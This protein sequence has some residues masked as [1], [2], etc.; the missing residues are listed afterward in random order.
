MSES[1]PRLKFFDAVSRTAII[2]FCLLNLTQPEMLQ[3]CIKFYPDQ[4]KS[5][6]D[7]D[8]NSFSFAL[9][10]SPPPPPPPPPNHSPSSHPLRTQTFLLP[11]PSQQ[12]LTYHR[13]TDL[14]DRFVV[15][16]VA[17]ARQAAGAL[18]RGYRHL[19]LWPGWVAQGCRSWR[20][21]WGI[22]GTT[23]AAR[24]LRKKDSVHCSHV[25]ETSTNYIASVLRYK[26]TGVMATVAPGSCLVELL[27]SLVF[28]KWS[29]IWL[30][31]P[32]KEGASCSR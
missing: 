16:D 20:W 1:I 15:G 11:I 19:A 28:L 10:P 8:A 3:H 26:P 25:P 6:W 7:N 9:T 2:S 23:V 18:C 31:I 24:P 13:G 14:R 17:S 29:R 22:A 4:L 12:L 27:N 32:R 5:V 30:T 21:S